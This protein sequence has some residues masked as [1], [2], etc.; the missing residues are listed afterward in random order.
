MLM[1][2]NSKKRDTKKG[3]LRNQAQPPSYKQRKL[4]TVNGKSP[5]L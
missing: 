3:G 1:W 4:Y 2:L 5:A